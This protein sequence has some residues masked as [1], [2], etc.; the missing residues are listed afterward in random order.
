MKLLNSCL[1]IR[2]NHI[3]IITVAV[4]QSCQALKL[5]HFTDIFSKISAT[6]A[7]QKITN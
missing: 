6:K 5:S 3:A 1:A 7:I 4:I 2:I